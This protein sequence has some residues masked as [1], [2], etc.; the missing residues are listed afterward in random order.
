LYKTVGWH[1]AANPLLQVYGSSKAIMIKAMKKKRIGPAQPML[2]R[3][4]GSTMTTYVGWPGDDPASE[5]KMR[6]KIP[7]TSAIETRV[8]ITCL[9]SLH[10]RTSR[11]IEVVRC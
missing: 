6:S 7:T 2:R 4:C 9:L 8:A 1:P 3:G 11:Q 5:V 10:G